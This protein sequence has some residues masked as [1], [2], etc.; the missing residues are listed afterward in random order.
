M[1]HRPCGCDCSLDRQCKYCLIH[2]HEHLK[3]H[4]CWPQL[5]EESQ[6][7]VLNFIE[8]LLLQHSKKVTQPKKPVFGSP[9]SSFKMSEDFDAPMNDFERL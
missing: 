8:F 9:K 7:Q 6:L 1:P 3:D 2:L 4:S 5:P